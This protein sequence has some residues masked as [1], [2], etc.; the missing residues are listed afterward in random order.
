[1]FVYGRF[2]NSKATT[3]PA[4]MTAMPVPT[5][6]SSY[7]GFAVGAEAVGV[8]EADDVLTTMLVAADEL[9]YESSAANVA[10][11]V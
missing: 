7:G 2:L 11:I 8:G 9:P 3:T 4:M 6:Y 1:M 5:V 10:M